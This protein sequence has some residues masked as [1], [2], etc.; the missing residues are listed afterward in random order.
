MREPPVILVGMMLSGKS[1]V[2]KR[3]ADKLNL[4]FFDL[5]KAIEACSGSTISALIERGEEMFREVESRT[6]ATHLDKGTTVVLATGGGAFEAVQ[7]R[8]CCLNSGFVVYLKAKTETL[9]AR[10]A[11][12]NTIRPL[13]KKGFPEKKLNELMLVREKNYMKA[14]W[15]IA[16]DGLYVDDIVNEIVNAYQSRD[17]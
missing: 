7:N 11:L 15:V 3:L 6:L 14:H 1:T 13:L 17:S 5:D 9:L 16:V 4:P 12:D 8:E 10:H 2:G